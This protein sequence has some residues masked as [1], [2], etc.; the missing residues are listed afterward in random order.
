[1]AKLYNLAR[2]TT[3]TTGTGT[4][5]LGS[6][7]NGF[8]SFSSAGVQDGDVVSYGI[9]D[10][11]NAEVG[12]GTYTAAGTTLTRTVTTSTN[13]NNAISLSGGAQVFIT[14]RAEDFAGPS[15]PG[16]RLTLTSGVPV[17]NRTSGSVS[18]A[19]TVYWTPYGGGLVPI[20][21][22]SRFFVIQC[23]E[24]SN[25]L[26][27]AGNAGPAAAVRNAVYD[28]YIE[29]ISG[30][31]ALVRSDMWQLVGAATNT[32]ANPAVFTQAGNGALN[33]TP[34]RL[35]AVGGGSLSPNFTPGVTYYVIG[36]N[37]GAG[38]F[39]LAA[40]PGGTPLAAGGPSTAV[41]QQTIIGI[42]NNNNYTNAVVRG[43]VNAQTRING[44][45]TGPGASLGTYV[46]SI[47]TNSS[48]GVDYIFGGIGA[49]GI[50]AS[51]GIYNE[52]NKELLT[53]NVIDTNSYSYSGATYRQ[54][55]GSSSGNTIDWLV[56]NRIGMSNSY[57]Q[58]C[59]TAAI[60]GAECK[61]AIGFDVVPASVDVPPFIVHTDGNIAHTGAGTTG[62]CH[63]DLTIGRHQMQAMESGAADGSGGGTFGNTDAGIGGILS[64]AIMN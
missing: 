15:I 44:I 49:G 60:A 2:M 9:S 30:V 47:Y 63:N 37:T 22:G 20:W 39:S 19:G 33:G 24:L 18:N 34:V 14:A 32:N 52:H 53:T 62:M 54:A 12:I 46:G 1:M 36:A 59:V 10:G 64:L 29:L 31:P 57:T 56:G 58:K 13:G 27:N 28:L 17:M 55:G 8:L 7:V 51:F 42:G 41:T 16:G 35:A 50:A 11:A 4:I 25:I 23:P 5:V 45:L 21:N 48:G 6:P 38:T 40:T 3:V 26:A 43:T 61:F